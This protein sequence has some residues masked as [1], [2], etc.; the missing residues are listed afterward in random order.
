[1]RFPLLVVGSQRFA[2]AAGV[3]GCLV[4]FFF[5]W[6]AKK[7]RLEDRHQ[8]RCNERAT[9]GI[10]FDTQAAFEG[11]RCRQ[12]HEA[13]LH[14]LELLNILHVLIEHT[15]E[16]VQALTVNRLHSL[17]LQLSRH[18]TKLARQIGVVLHRDAKTHPIEHK[19]QEQQTCSEA[20]SRKQNIA[21]RDGDF[22]NL[23]GGA[24]QPH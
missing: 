18:T 3:L 17:L 4:K 20:Q 12:F 15:L 14:G 1:V 21:R 22:F 2:H 9:S 7:P 19:T 6:L 8:V 16:L 13:V 5:K 23:A 24:R 10:V 11:S